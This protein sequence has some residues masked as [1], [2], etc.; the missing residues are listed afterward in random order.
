MWSRCMAKL[1]LVSSLICERESS[2]IVSLRS[3]LLDICYQLAI[4]ELIIVADLLQQKQLLLFD[5]SLLAR[6]IAIGD[7]RIA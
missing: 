4:Q 3:S 2:W 5:S 1:D 7:E 6:E